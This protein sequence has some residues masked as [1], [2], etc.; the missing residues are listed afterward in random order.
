MLIFEH[1]KETILAIGAFYGATAVVLGAFGAHAFKK[2]L[3]EER[4]SSFETGVRYQM[5]HALLLLIIGL[6][7]GATGDSY[8]TAAWFVVVGTALFSFSIYLL[9]FKDYWN[10]NLRF[11]G[12][13]TPLG[14]LCLVVGWVLLLL[15]FINN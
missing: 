2:I 6:L 12:P 3:S 13:V 9:S 7:A 4:L 8:D 11:L 1:M 10:I 15:K 14:G 5:Y